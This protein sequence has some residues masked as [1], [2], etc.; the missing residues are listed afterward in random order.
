MTHK[1]ERHHFQS[2]TDWLSRWTTLE[3]V[4]RSL[5]DEPSGGLSAWARTTAGVVAMLLTLQVVT[6]AL[7]SFYYVPSVESAHATVAYME[8]VVPAGSWIRALHHYGSQWLTLFLILH[9]VQMFWRASY[10][11]R[12]LGW[13]ASVLL[14]AL[15]LANGATGYSLPWDARA[16]FSTRV[17]EGIAEGLPL[18]GPAARSW[19]LGSAEISPLTL[20]RLYALHLIVVPALIFIVVAARLFVFRE[21]VKA[22]APLEQRRAWMR[23]QLARNAVASGLV[24]L[25]LA[26]FANRFHAPLGPAAD[27][28]MHTYLPRPGAQFLWLFQMLKYLPGRT[29]S[30]VAVALPGLIL[31]ALAL[32][33]FLNHAPLSSLLAHPRRKVGIALFTLALLLFTLLTALA[34]LEDARDPRVRAQLA[35]QAAEEEAFRAAPFAPLRLRTSESDTEEL[36]TDT[37][38]HRRT[39][40]ANT[41]MSSHPES[42]SPTT[43]LISASSPPDAYIA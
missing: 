36:D 1:G 18:I 25:A 9:L 7:L 10:R 40:A 19:L 24:F 27:T 35:R 2:T 17:A 20:A 15:V 33:P 23:S 34:Y 38:M 29:A 42:T 37:G 13:V 14:L 11:R 8:K 21:R 28:A 43:P 41:S 4:G 6:G 39:E 31:I 3:E 26:L 16:F 32:L 5:V 30:L 12:P 22:S